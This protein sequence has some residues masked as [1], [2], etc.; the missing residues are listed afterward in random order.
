MHKIFKVHSVQH[1]ETGNHF[2]TESKVCVSITVIKNNNKH[3]K[4]GDYS[5]PL[6]FWL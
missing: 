4:K 2:K 1:F 6:F 3:V 5:V